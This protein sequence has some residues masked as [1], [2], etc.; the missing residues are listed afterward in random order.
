MGQDNSISSLSGGSWKLAP[1]SDVPESGEQISAAG[2]ST[3][4]WLAA[5][6]PGTV[7]GSYV[8]AG[9]EKDPNFGDNIY[10]V[11]VL[12]TTAIFGIAPTSL[13]PSPIKADGYG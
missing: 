3:A 11:D 4:S 13:F 1:Q 2:F 8:L 12:S 7:F 6:V 10:Q 9:K 5:Q